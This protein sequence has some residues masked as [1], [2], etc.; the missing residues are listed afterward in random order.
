M[1]VY[2]MHRIGSDVFDTTGAFVFPGRWH[3]AGIRLVYAAEHASLAALET[4]I[5]AG[6]RAVPNKTMTEIQVPEDISIESS[7]WME[8]GQSQTFGSDWLRSGRSA[9]LKVPGKAV[10][11]MESNFLINP[12]H[13][14]SARIRAGRTRDFAFD[15]R[16]FEL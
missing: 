12:G 10:N 7:A 8:I 11:M 4:L 9:V 13:L 15:T 1:I 16:F 14:D 6:Q 3:L 2:R 5:H